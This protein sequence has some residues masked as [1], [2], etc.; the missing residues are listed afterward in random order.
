MR[1]GRNH[2]V[3]TTMKACKLSRCATQGCHNISHVHFRNIAVILSKRL[4][5]RR[6]EKAILNPL[7]YDPLQISIFEK[8]EPGAFCGGQDDLLHD[9]RIKVQ[10]TEGII[11]QLLR[12]GSFLQ[13]RYLYARSDCLGKCMIFGNDIGCEMVP[14]HDMEVIK[15]AV[16]K[17]LEHMVF[18][19]CRE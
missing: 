16:F 3:C 9:I 17:R 15:T 10:E 2:T 7:F 1:Y 13:E 5:N 11:P 18:F 14:E 8:E 6:Q 4:R 12:K 19:Q